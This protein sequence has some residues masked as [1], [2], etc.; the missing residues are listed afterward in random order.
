[1]TVT[2]KGMEDVIRKLESLDSPAVFKRP[3]TQAV[4]HLHRKIGKAVTKAPGAFSAMATPGQRRA[5][6]A[7]VSSNEITHT[8]SGYRRSGQLGKGWTTRVSP[9]GRRGEVGTNVPYAVYVQGERQQPFHAASKYPKVED[10]AEDERD[11]VLRF[12]EREYE[13]Q[14]A[15]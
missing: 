15:R 7:K 14:L 13:R 1:M 6:W 12:F 2:I 3:M 11:T 4:Q 5:Y 8:A 10:V 9:N